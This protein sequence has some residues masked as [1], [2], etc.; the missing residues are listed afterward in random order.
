MKIIVVGCGKVGSV[1]AE[2]LNK[3]NHEVTVI[4][5]NAAKLEAMLEKLDVQSYMG[6]GSSYKVLMS[7][8]VKNADL[9]IAVTSKDE[10]NLLCCLM[11]RKVGNCHTIARVRDFTF[12][13][14][15]N[16]IK[17]ELGLSMYVNPEY[18]AAREIARLVQVPSAMELDVFAKGRVNMVGI[19]IEDG[20]ILDGMRIIDI[21]T[22]IN[23]NILACII[24]R[25]GDTIIPNGGDFIRKGDNVSFIVPIFEM[26][27]V[28]QR[29]GAVVK[30][31][32]NVMIAGGG[33]VAYYLAVM[34]KMA[35][36]KVKIIERDK[37]RCEMLSEQ[38]SDDAII[39]NGDATDRELLHEEGIESTDAFVSLT[40]MDEENIMLSLYANEVSQAKLI[41][42]VNKITFNNVIKSL[43]IGSVISPKNIIA[44]RIIRYV[45]TF[46]NTPGSNVESLYR[47]NE[48]VEA[49]EFKVSEP[50]KNIVDI[51]LMDL[52]LKSD[53]IICSINRKGRV[54]TP[55][56]KDTIQTGDLVIVVTT[57]AG[58]NDLRE[59]VEE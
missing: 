25:G 56:G 10:T 32:K 4:D 43:P 50:V 26:T 40:N 39:I 29:I 53:L 7:A 55:N 22:K 27:R 36:V 34:L 47:I 59:I 31:I 9:V 57:H 23:E 24:E 52:K 48:N 6:N 45:R 18:E 37:K 15:I 1:L 19:K 21:R 3:E 58:L 49:I 8:G 46:K 42:K 5:S 11:S 38:L 16:I 44:E 33:T 2:Q 17:D 20:S 35:H 13:D 54:F 30:P 28:F 41:T 14:E 12:Y 51:P